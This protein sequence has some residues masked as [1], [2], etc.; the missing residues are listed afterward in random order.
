MDGL[1]APVI[2]WILKKCSIPWLNAMMFYL[3]VQL[4]MLLLVSALMSVVFDWSTFTLWQSTSLD[5]LTGA[6]K[7]DQLV[8][9]RQTKGNTANVA[10]W[11]KATGILRSSSVPTRSNTIPQSKNIPKPQKEFTDLIDNSNSHFVP[12]LRS[13]PNAKRPLSASRSMITSVRMNLLCT[14]G[15]TH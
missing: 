3:K 11:N 13:K 12:V 14:C 15:Q 2:T 10:S 5:D 6:N 7:Q 9:P 1:K 4:V 8:E